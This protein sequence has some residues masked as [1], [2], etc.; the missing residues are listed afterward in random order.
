MNQALRIPMKYAFL[1]AVLFLPAA[2]FGQCKDAVSTKDMQDCVD[3]EWK[4]AD[5]ELNHTYQETLK[6]LKP[7]AADLLKKAQRAWITY[8]DAHCDAEYKMWQGGTAAGVALVQCRATL[9][10]R[11]T[12]EIQETYSPNG[13]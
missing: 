10:Q 13:N 2:A 8:R 5:A 7:D 1:L 3:A 6:K 11:R 9:T 4:K 12:K